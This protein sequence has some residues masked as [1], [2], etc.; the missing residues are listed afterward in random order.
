M[1]YADGVQILHRGHHNTLRE[2]RVAIKDDVADFELRPFIDRE[3]DIHSTRRHLA[4]L[5]RYGCILMAAFGFVIGQYI[6]SALHFAWI[7]SRFRRRS[8]K[9]SRISDLLMDLL[10]V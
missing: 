7:E 1:R 6:F 5:R 2:N 4:N 8:L 10:P 9:R 3:G